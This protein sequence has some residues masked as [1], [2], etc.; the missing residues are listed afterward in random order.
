MRPAALRGVLTEFSREIE[1]KQAVEALTPSE[2]RKTI[3][4]EGENQ[5]R[6]SLYRLT[7]SWEGEATWH[8]TLYCLTPSW[9][10]E[11]QPNLQLGAPSAGQATWHTSFY[12]LTPFRRVE[13]QPN[14]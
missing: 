7:P 11:K 4:K 1:A 2:C 10:G 14:L 9:R 8:T 3:E 12:C 5:R 13:K 6:T